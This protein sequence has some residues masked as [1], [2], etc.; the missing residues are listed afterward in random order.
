MGNRLPSGTTLYQGC[1]ADLT[2]NKDNLLAVVTDNEPAKGNLIIEPSTGIKDTGCL[3]A[4]PFEWGSLDILTTPAPTSLPV[5]E[6]HV[7]EAAVAKKG[8][9]L[10]YIIIGIVIL[11][12]MLILLVGCLLFKRHNKDKGVYKVDEAVTTKWDW[13]KGILPV[14]TERK[15]SPA[16]YGKVGVDTTD[17]PE[18]F[19]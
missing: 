9:S 11:V 5:T 18:V 8:S 7:T 12:I 6:H 3:A 1:L 10:P 15:A 2:F 16:V 19:A 17:N 14:L 13:K 4:L